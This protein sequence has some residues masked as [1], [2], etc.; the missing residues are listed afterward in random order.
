MFDAMAMVPAAGWAQI[1]V[2]GAAFELTAWNRQW[3]EDRAVPGD[4]GYD[5]LGLT[6]GP[7]GL[8]S[9]VMTKMRIKEIKNGR[10]AM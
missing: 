4:Y 3:N 5:P 2:C 8:D 7:G 1:F 10:L 6:K 9:E